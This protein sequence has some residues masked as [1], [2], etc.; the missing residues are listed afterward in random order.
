MNLKFCRFFCSIFTV[1]IIFT[2]CINAEL[3]LTRI[4]SQNEIESLITYMGNNCSEAVKESSSLVFL[5]AY[6]CACQLYANSTFIYKCTYGDDIVGM[7]VVDDWSYADKGYLRLSELL[8]RK[9]K[10]GDIDKPMARKILEKI[11]SDVLPETKTSRLIPE[12]SVF[13]CYEFY[14]NPQ[15]KNKVRTSSM[16]KLKK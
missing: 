13:K 9:S 3:V 11:K 12:K 1:L 15:I 5:S 16:P 6:V 14:F 4:T 10:Y 2:S 8:V 7:F